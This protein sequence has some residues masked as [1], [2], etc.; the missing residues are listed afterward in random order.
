MAGDW[1]KLETV[2]PDKPEVLLMADL[3]GIA[4]EHVLGCLVRVWIWADQQSLDGN[5]ITVTDSSLDRIARN[6][7]VTQAMCDVGWVRKLS[8]GKDGMPNTYSLPNF[9]RHNG[10]SSK[11]RALATK[12]V[13]RFRNANVTPQAL[14]EKRREYI[15]PSAHNAPVENPKPASQTPPAPAAHS[16]AKAQQAIQES[17]KALET[18][19]PMPDHLAAKIT[20]HKPHTQATEPSDGFDE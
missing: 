20:R 11:K 9:E 13:K 16:I 2:T 4:P 6:A 12:R 1:I 3:L 17:R 14:P 7:G 15:K 5:A 10:E 18:R 8:T 19:A